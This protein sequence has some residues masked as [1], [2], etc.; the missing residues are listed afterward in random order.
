MTSR[1]VVRHAS[2]V[3][4]SSIRMSQDWNSLL[5]LIDFIVDALSCSYFS[6]ELL[7]RSVSV[8]V[9]GSCRGSLRLT[10]LK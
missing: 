1:R 6:T 8:A 7:N 4:V 9:S 10:A 5:G 2:L 3:V